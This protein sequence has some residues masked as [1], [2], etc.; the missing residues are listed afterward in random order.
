MDELIAF[1]GY[2]LILRF[3]DIGETLMTRSGP[4]EAGNSSVASET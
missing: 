1:H 3:M 2:Q 4:M